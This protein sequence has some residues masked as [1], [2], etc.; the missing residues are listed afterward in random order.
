ML[1]IRTRG[2]RMEGANESTE[3]RRHPPM[4]VF[5]DDINFSTNSIPSRTLFSRINDSI[6]IKEK[7]QVLT[8]ANLPKALGISFGQTKVLKVQV[9][10]N[11]TVGFIQ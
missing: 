10:N 7:L 9:G 11:I 8:F 5:I 1:G 6:I 3:L 2:S 4:S